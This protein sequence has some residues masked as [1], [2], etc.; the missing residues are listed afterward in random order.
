[1]GTAHP[2]SQ[3]GRAA[4]ATSRTPVSIFLP[5]RYVERVHRCGPPASSAT[6]VVTRV[7]PGFP[8]V[9]IREGAEV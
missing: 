9:Q 8:G 1:M 4:A 5:P 6:P 3:T 7:P 2:G